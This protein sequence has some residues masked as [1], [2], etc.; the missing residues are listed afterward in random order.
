MARRVSVLLAILVSLSAVPAWAQTTALRFVSQPGDYIGGGLTQTWNSGDLTLAVDTVRTTTTR[1]VIHGFKEPFDGNLW[2][3]LEFVAP[4]NSPFAPGA[5]ERTGNV[6]VRSPQHPGLNVFGSG[7]ACNKATGRFVVHEAVFS[8]GAL[9]SFAADFEQHCEDGVPAL[10]GAMRFN[11]SRSSLDPFD[12]VYPLYSLHVDSSP[13][14]RVS[15]PGIDC[16]AGGIDCDEQ[17]GAP[18]TAALTV[19]AA[20]GYTF[21]AWSGDCEGQLAPAS[22]VVTQR[23]T[24]TPV[25]DAQPGSG[26][27][28]PL[29]PGTLLVI[30]RQAVP[31]HA[32]DRWLALPSDS[33]FTVAAGATG[34]TF[35]VKT[36]NG[37][38]VIVSFAPRTG[39][40]LAPGVY[41]QARGTPFQSTH[42][43]GFGLSGLATGCSF[44]R[45]RY[46]IYEM[47][48]DGA[49]KLERFAADFERHCDGEIPAVAGAI[50][51]NST[52]AAAIPFDGAYPLYKLTIE[53]SPFGTISSAGIECSGSGGP[54][55]EET[56][57]G[58]GTV[59]LTAQ[60]LPGFTFVGWTGD[61]TGST[62]GS[63]FVTMTMVCGAVFDNA[64]GPGTEDVRL[65]SLMFFSE[66][67]DWVGRGQRQAWTSADSVFEVVPWVPVPNA[68]AH[69]NV[70]RPDGNIYALDFTAPVGQVLQ[71][72]DYVNA[73]RYGF[74]SASRPGMDVR[75][76]GRGCNVI[77]GRFR[78]YEVHFDSGGK[79]DVFAADFEQH[80][81]GRAAALYGAIRF[82]ST[83]GVLLPFD[84]AFLPRP[85]VV[86]GT[87]LY[88]STVTMP[89]LVS[90]WSVNLGETSGTGVDAIHLYAYPASG[91]AP[92]FL[93]V[94]SYGAARPD[95]GNMFGTPFT[96]SGFNLPG[97]RG[98][99][100][101]KYTLAA[102]AHDTLTGTF[103]AVTTA[104]FTVP[105]PV[106]APLI[107][108]GAPAAGATVL[109]GLEIDGWALDTGAFTGTGIDAV[110]IYVN[111]AGSGAVAFLGAAEYGRSRPDV[112]AIFGSTFTPSGF[113][114]VVAPESVQSLTPGAYTLLVYARS[115]LTGQYSLATASFT[116]VSTAM[117]MNP[118]ADGAHVTG[119]FLIAGWAIDADAP[120][121]SGV[122]AIHAWAVPASGAPFFLGA[123][124]TDAARPDIAAIFGAR[125]LVSGYNLAA[126]VLPPGTYVIAVYAHSA[127]TG[128]FNQVRTATVIV[129]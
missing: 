30:D 122:D 117:S 98:L 110:H 85:I 1:I 75:G 94:A 126:P 17:Y 29:T 35:T 54:D 56:Y 66:R 7:R 43:P 80:C 127:A 104:E 96:N 10:F 79:P 15:G 27:P 45:A 11:S 63:V 44:I 59:P 102:I 51:F 108:I 114:L 109:G 91:G 47:S 124:T 99:A 129:E 103:D 128:S 65:G 68:E 4:D 115:T 37:E 111:R 100:P 74:E 77:S 33:K 14:G 84:G 107:A 13:F 22:I 8:S 2:W 64:S 73:I 40:T 57:T 25:F 23:R 83:R 50:R 31:Y 67:D 118:P 76:N 116:R 12:G 92:T 41:D 120:S 46:T 72:G 90:G 93:G 38:D 82:N 26:T 3:D 81:E 32:A 5:Y 39:Q 123:T 105:P 28:S 87:P 88:G 71:P 9:V 60:P 119:A 70:K 106:S 52:R 18:G 69:F 61:C 95:V 19:A 58:G 97:A 6:F 21:L 20:P 42:F 49:G 48:F 101:G 55:C 86:I 78:V 34:I 53:P 121:G 125:F 36:W 89:F 24:C 62:R 16:G 112:G 113:H